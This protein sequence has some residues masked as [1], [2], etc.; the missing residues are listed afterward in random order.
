M[1]N[2]TIE[3]YRVNKR[4]FQ[5]GAEAVQYAVDG[6]LM[7]MTEM[8]IKKNLMCYPHHREAWQQGL[9]AY[10]KLKGEPNVADAAGSKD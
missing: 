6:M 10:K 5:R 2:N 4:R 8:D 3:M 1:S 7:W 9:D